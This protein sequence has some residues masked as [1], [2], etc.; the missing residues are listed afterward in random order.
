MKNR[1]LSVSDQDV[2]FMASSILGAFTA[3]IVMQTVNRGD[4]VSAPQP[5][6]SPLPLISSLMYFC[7]FLFFFNSTHS[8]PAGSTHFKPASVLF[9]L[10]H[11]YQAFI[12]FIFNLAHSYQAFFIHFQPEALI[13][14]PLH[15]FSSRHTHS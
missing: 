7:F 13:S 9:K 12:S 15:S 2:P 5:I 10:A 8:Y 1:Q 3:F 14:S 4:S 6:P 11:S